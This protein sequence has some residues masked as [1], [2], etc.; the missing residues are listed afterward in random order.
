MKKVLFL[1]LVAFM[2]FL[3]LV[4]TPYY[5]SMQEPEDV[6]VN[7]GH[8]APALRPIVFYEASVLSVVAPYELSNVTVVIRDEDGEILYSYSTLFI[9]GTLEVTLPCAED[10]MYSVEL[11][12]SGHH[13][14]GYF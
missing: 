12:Y 6:E 11:I 13:L 4:A 3:S 10:A 2:P 14:I 5:I 9:I 7:K 1:F 8:R